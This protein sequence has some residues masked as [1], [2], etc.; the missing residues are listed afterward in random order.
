MWFSIESA[1]A[2]EDSRREARR[3]FKAGEDGKE[4][5]RVSISSDSCLASLNM[6]PFW[7]S[8]TSSLRLRGIMSMND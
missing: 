3:F 4:V 1:G 7:P 8:L 2:L 6:S 5:R